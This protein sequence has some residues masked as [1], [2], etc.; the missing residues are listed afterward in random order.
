MKATP[1]ALLKP[2]VPVPNEDGTPEVD[3]RIAARNSKNEEIDV[4][5]ARLRRE[6]LA[7]VTGGDHVL[8]CHLLYQTKPGSRRA[9]RRC[10]A[11]P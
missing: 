11:E 3:A 10:R 4:T 5:N 9:D 1:K 8:C 6:H 7:R 2:R